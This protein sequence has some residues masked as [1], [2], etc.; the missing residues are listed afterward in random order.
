MT[1]R[2]KIRDYM[3]THLATLAPETELIRAMRLLLDRKISGAPVVD[4][5]GALVGLPSRDVH[6]CGGR[7]YSLRDVP[8]RRHLG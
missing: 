1:Q 6:G 7:L 3:A 8:Q 4:A 5:Q 2:P